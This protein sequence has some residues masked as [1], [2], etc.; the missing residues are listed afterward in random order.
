M[1]M[2]VLSSFTFSFSFRKRFTASISDS[3]INAGLFNQYTRL[4]TPSVCFIDESSCSETFTKTY[5][6]IM[7]HK[8]FSY[9]RSIAV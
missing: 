3:R 9:G 6:V 7:A 8:Q 1:P 2:G 4:I 5:D